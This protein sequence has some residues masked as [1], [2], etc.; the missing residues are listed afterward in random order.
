MVPFQEE[1]VEEEKE[2]EAENDD[3]ENDEPSWKM[4]L[5]LSDEDYVL[6]DSGVPMK[7][8]KVKRM[9]GAF[10]RA[11]REPTESHARPRRRPCFKC[12]RESLILEPMRNKAESVD[13]KTTTYI[14]DVQNSSAAK[15]QHACKKSRRKIS[16][17]Q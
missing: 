15:L 13:K 11:L 7:N 1:E 16:H 4:D 14:Y 5:K 8:P 9:V 17:R 2:E 3:M 10:A 12:N 6:R